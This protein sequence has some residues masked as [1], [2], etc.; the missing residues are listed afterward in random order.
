MRVR[1][2]DAHRSLVLAASADQRWDD[3][4]WFTGARDYQIVLG[5]ATVGCRP[6][7]KTLAPLLSVA[8]S[9]ESIGACSF[10]SP[11]SP[12]RL[13]CGCWS[14]AGAAIRQRR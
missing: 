1:G 12:S 6:Q 5:F 10:H 3:L 11:I 2:V 13:C 8:S 9:D 7:I 14:A 4:F